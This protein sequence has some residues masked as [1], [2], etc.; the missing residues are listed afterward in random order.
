MVAHLPD[1]CGPAFEGLWP[2][3]DSSGG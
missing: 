2:R 3:P 1:D